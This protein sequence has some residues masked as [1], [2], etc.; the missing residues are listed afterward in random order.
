MCVDPVFFLHGTAGLRIAVHAKGQR[1]D[2]QINL[3]AFP[4]NFIKKQQDGSSPVNHKLIARLMLDVHGKLILCNVVLISLAVLGIA[5]W[6]LPGAL[7]EIDILL[8]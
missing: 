3:A 6:R 8:P 1:C 7:A 2:K 5:I 4:Y